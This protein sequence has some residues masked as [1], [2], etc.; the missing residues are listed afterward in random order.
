MAGELCCRNGP[1][2]YGSLRPASAV[3]SGVVHKA[4]GLP[5][6]HV[7]VRVEGAGAT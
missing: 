2:L 3:D 1:F 5:I 7:E 6:S 4:G